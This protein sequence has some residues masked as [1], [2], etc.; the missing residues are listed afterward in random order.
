M[1]MRLLRCDLHE[2]NRLVR[3]CDAFHTC[4]LLCH[5]G[6]VTQLIEIARYHPR[7]NATKRIDFSCYWTLNGPSKTIREK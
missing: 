4:V 1:Q 7:Y 6:N 5:F 3:R 2:T